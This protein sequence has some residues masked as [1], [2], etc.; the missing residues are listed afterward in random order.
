MNEFKKRIK[1]WFKIYG[2]LIGSDIGYNKL[3]ELLK[4]E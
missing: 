1:E 3:E 2:F 4:N